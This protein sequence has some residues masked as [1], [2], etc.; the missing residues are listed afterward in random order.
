MK[1]AR[2]AHTS[3]DGIIPRLVA[4]QPD[5]KRVIDLATAERL[6]LERLG[7]THKAAYSHQLKAH[8]T[9][10]RSSNWA[11]F[12][13]FL[14]LFI[15]QPERMRRAIKRKAERRLR[16][17]ASASMS[18]HAVARTTLASLTRLRCGSCQ[19]KSTINQCWSS[20]PISLAY[21]SHSTRHASAV[22]H[23]STW[24]CCFHRLYN[25][26]ICQRS[27][28][29][30]KA[31]SKRKRLAGT[32][33][34]KMVQSAKRNVSALMGCCRRCASA[35]KSSRRLSAI[36]LGTRSS[37]RRIGRRAAAPTSTRSSFS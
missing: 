28:N 12:G 18:V 33:V 4:V 19:A 14:R 1:L 17:P 26:S 23:S 32:S 13:R 37:S 10:S 7:A 8:S 24:P 11:E 15:W 30:T 16:W 35:S 36:F 22:C 9:A 29:S 2:I 5:Q 21:N 31:S 6:R 34:S 3:P 27:R 25:S 20:A